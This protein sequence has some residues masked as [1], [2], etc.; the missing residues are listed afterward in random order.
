MSYLCP[1]VVDE[2]GNS[3]TTSVFLDE[4]PSDVAGKGCRDHETGDE[5]DDP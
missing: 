4:V 2:R 3:V 5:A 1:D